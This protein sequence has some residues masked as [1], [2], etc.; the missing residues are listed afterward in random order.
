MAAP[1]QIK[2]MQTLLEETQPP[3]LIQ[4]MNETRMGIGAVLRCLDETQQAVTVAGS[5]RRWGSPG[6]I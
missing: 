6:R 1:E 2:L 3:M 4:S 5:V